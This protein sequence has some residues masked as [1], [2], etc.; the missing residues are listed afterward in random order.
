M[1]I[2]QLDPWI[3]FQLYGS[4]CCGKINLMRADQLGVYSVPFDID[5]SLKIFS[6]HS[7]FCCNK[8]VSFVLQHFCFL[9]CTVTKFVQII[10][11]S[12]SIIERTVSKFILIFDFTLQTGMC[13]W[14]PFQIKCIFCMKDLAFCN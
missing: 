10:L 3:G 8:A 14:N 7:S 5:F 11:Q 1:L 13:L 2:V 6:W 9:G 12:N 4:S